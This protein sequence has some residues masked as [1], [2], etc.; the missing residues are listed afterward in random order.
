MLCASRHAADGVVLIHKMN[1]AP[2][3]Y[4]RPCAP[5]LC[6]AQP[7]YLPLLAAQRRYAEAMAWYERA[8][9]LE[10]RRWIPPRPLAQS[11]LAHHSS[12]RGVAPIFTK[13]R[14]IRPRPS[15]LCALAGSGARPLRSDPAP[16]GSGATLAALGFTAQLAG[17]HSEAVERYHQARQRELRIVCAHLCRTPVAQRRSCVAHSTAHS[18]RGVREAGATAARKGIALH[19]GDLC[20]RTLPDRLWA[21]GQ[22]TASPWRCSQSACAPRRLFCRRCFHRCSRMLEPKSLKRW[23]GRVG[24]RERCS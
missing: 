11:S 12:P 2:S 17:R 9:A 24:G 14:S 23:S 8:L 10:P 4:F 1:I 20:P 6:S 7:P 5:S 15:P 21:C 19:C 22:M 13:P 16:P 18:R 3:A